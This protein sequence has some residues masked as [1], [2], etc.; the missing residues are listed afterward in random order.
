MPAD[1]YP[2][3]QNQFCNT[4]KSCI[5]SIRNSFPRISNINHKI[6]TNFLSLGLRSSGDNKTDFN[7]IILHFN[8]RRKLFVT[9]CDK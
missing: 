4:E 7:L 8:I 5:H 2:L 6:K 9:R 3:D 1:F